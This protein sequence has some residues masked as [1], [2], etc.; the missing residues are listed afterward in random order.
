MGQVSHSSRGTILPSMP[1][2]DSIVV[3]HCVVGGTEQEMGQSQ[4]QSGSAPETA[5]FS[6]QQ[7]SVVWVTCT[8]IGLGHMLQTPLVL[9]GNSDHA[10]RRASAEGHRLQ[11][12]VGFAC[13]QC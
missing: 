12:A 9:E 7:A 8:G 11:G 13:D 1:H 2:S 5:L 10:L 3:K 6:G 4:G